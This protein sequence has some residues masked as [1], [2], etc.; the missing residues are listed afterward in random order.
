MS[1]AWDAQAD[2]IGP[3]LL[4]S[5]FAALIFMLFETILACRATDALPPCLESQAAPG[6]AGKCSEELLAVC[7]APVGKESSELWCVNAF[8]VL[9]VCRGRTGWAKSVIHDLEV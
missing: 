3:F 8:Q 5:R 2:L 1:V 6:E 7:L 4:A 9:G